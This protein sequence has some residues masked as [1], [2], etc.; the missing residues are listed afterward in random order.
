MDVTS[1]LFFPVKVPSHVL[2]PAVDII[3]T[4]CA[5]INSYPSLAGHDLFPVFLFPLAHCSFDFAPHHGTSRHHP[6]FS[7][8]TRLNPTLKCR[9]RAQQPQHQIPSSCKFPPL[10]M[11]PQTLPDPRHRPSLP[12]PTPTPLRR[13]LHI[14][15]RYA[16][17]ALPR[18]VLHGRHDSRRRPTQRVLHL[19]RD[20]RHRRR[21]DHHLRPLLQPRVRTGMVPFPRRT[22]W[23]V[24]ELSAG[25]V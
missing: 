25:V 8:R 10:T 3:S 23:V 2:L 16:N 11:S 21:Q 18:R 19:H 4:Q 20:P 12:T 6:Q 13:N 5:I 17:S 14:N 15:S 7:T 1:L 9:P 24:S 22:P